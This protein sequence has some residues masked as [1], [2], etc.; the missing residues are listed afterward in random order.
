MKQINEYDKSMSCENIDECKFN[1]CA[2]GEHSICTD[3]IG[4]YEC[5]CKEGYELQTKA[6]KP[7]KGGG[8]C[9]LIQVNECT[10]GLHNCDENAICI[11][12]EDSFKCE[13]PEG[14]KFEKNLFISLL[15]AS[16]MKILNF[17]L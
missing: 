6:G 7:D 8:N 14:K 15:T 9:K 2:M 13:C 10:A 17:I 1:P 11:D 16:F 5:S 4:G 3:T 12:T